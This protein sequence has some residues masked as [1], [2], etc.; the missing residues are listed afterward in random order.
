[1]TDALNP[2]TWLDHYGD[3]LYRY[4][5]LRVRD[6]AVAEDLVQ[7]TLLAGIK[8]VSNFSGKSTV[9]T[10]L[11]GILKHKII[12][13]LRKQQR[14]PTILSEQDL[15]ADLIDYQFDGQGH[16]QNA[17]APWS[18]PEQAQHDEQFRQIFN[19]CL[20]RLP[21]QMAQLFIL[22]EMDG[23]S[24]Q[25]LCKLLDISTT[26]NLWVILSRTRMKLRLCLESRWFESPK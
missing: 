24:S 13:Y 5:L 1:M 10:W 22:R 8:S 21:E 15:G 2:E 19:E 16:W 11:T 7:E 3:A 6:S 23:L 12:D 4:A 18:N 14:E 25:N 26:N 17:P 9:Q 20:D